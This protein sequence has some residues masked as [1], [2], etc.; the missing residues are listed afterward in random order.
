MS[1]FTLKLFYNHRV[2]DDALPGGKYWIYTTRL[3]ACDHVAVMEVGDQTMVAGIMN[4]GSR[5]VD[6]T[7]ESY[8]N[9]TAEGR[10][11][12]NVRG[13]GGIP[14]YDPDAEICTKA[15]VENSHGKTT[16]VIKI[17]AEGI[18]PQ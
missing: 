12:R 15:I 1:N 13:G 10:D 8:E 2:P 14:Q 4:D 16:Q 11:N 17:S 6:A 3:Y 18:K 7:V 9:S 5:S